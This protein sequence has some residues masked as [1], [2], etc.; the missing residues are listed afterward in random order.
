M[1]IKSPET[2]E[3]YEKYCDIRW[4]ILRAPWNRPKHKIEDEIN[5]KSIKLIACEDNGEV[6][7]TGRVRLNSTTE[8]EIKSMTVE[9]NYR[10]KGIGTK[11][12]SELERR[13][14]E[15]TAK[16]IVINS[17]DTA[18]DFYKKH[19]YKVMEKSCNI[20]GDLPHFKML[21]KL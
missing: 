20:Y 10:G 15:S 12:I 3:E 1:I 11:I 2:R 5:D 17:R 14:K 13:A 4:R 6:I 7:G 9:E 18:V 8:A 21:K 19:G 16:T